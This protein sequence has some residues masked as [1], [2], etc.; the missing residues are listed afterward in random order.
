L[1][2]S[3]ARGN[4]VA[5]V[6]LFCHE[7]IYKIKVFRFE[8]KCDCKPKMLLYRVRLSTMISTSGSSRGLM[9]VWIGLFA[10][11]RVNPTR[12]NSCEYESRNRSRTDSFKAMDLQLGRKRSKNMRSVS[13][14]NSISS[15][16]REMSEI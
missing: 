2:L 11:L 3:D 13:Q 7:E 5:F 10:L 6:H 8:N 4:P 14:Q 16:S 12:S 1:G 9:D 15:T